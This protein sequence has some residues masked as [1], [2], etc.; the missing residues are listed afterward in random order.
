[1]SREAVACNLTPDEAGTLHAYQILVVE[2]DYGETEFV[3]WKSD[4]PLRGHRRPGA[5]NTIEDALDALASHI[6]N[7][8]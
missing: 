8:E 7:G 3:I 2:D 4:G 6:R 5:Y 1:M